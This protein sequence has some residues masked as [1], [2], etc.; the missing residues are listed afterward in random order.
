MGM[1]SVVQ[2]HFKNWSGCTGQR[3]G[4]RVIINPQAIIPDK[5]VLV[6][7]SD[8]LKKRLT[9]SRKTLKEQTDPNLRAEE[10]ERIRRL[11]IIRSEIDFLIDTL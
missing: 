2:S 9:K 7:C 5:N 10:R 1:G 6:Q 8:G 11:N 3:N 4:G